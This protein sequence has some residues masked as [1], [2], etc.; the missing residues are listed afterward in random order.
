M[1]LLTE[2]IPNNTSLIWI[3]TK[4]NIFC[5]STKTNRTQKMHS[6]NY[7]AGQND[8][9]LVW[10]AKQT[11]TKKLHILFDQTENSILTNQNISKEKRKKIKK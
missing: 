4:N 11:T 7:C 1:C 6:F 2:L 5:K 8:C 10:K 9:F 3:N